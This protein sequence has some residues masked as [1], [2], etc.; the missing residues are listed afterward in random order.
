MIDKPSGALRRG[1]TTGACASAATKAAF[2]ALITSEFPTSVSIV[3]PKG[4]QPEFTLC[5]T[6]LGKDFSTAAII[7]DAGDDPDVTHGAEISVTVRRG[8]PGAGVVFKAGSGV[9]TITKAGLALDIGEPAINPVPRKMMCAV[10]SEIAEKFKHS[11]DVILTVAVVKGEELAKKTWNPRLG[12]LGG[13]SILG[14]TGIVIPYSCSAWIH[15]IHRGIDVARANDLPHVAG[16]TGSTS[17]KFVQNH[18]GLPDEAMLDMGDFAG[19]LLKYF[20]KHPLPKLTIGGGFGKLTKLAQGHLDLHSGRSQVDFM[21]LAEQ[22][23]ILG[24]NQEL[25]E[26]TK[27]ANTA[28]EVLQLAQKVGLPLADRIAEQACLVVR[29]ALRNTE[30][31]L[32]ILVINRQGELVG[33]A[34]NEH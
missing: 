20:R 33:E 23:K 13:I 27:S 7:K 8:I 12:I 32:K 3:L 22:L 19:G 16:C 30:T 15:S 31:Q 14:T 26:Q 9:G 5:H 11:G 17:E 28:N 18:Y 1:W 4:E 25:C 2:T 6:K 10:V 21:K 34:E 24:A 29:K